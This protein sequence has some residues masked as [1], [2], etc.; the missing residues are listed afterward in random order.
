MVNLFR[1]VTLHPYMN[2]GKLPDLY[3]CW[4]CGREYRT[5][6]EAD[7]CHNAGSYP[8]YRD[9]TKRKRTVFGN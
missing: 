9:G 7:A 5:K 2:T 8:V 4:F 3:K 1:K 6:E